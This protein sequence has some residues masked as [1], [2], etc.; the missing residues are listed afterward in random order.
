M[1]ELCARV[2]VSVSSYPGDENKGELDEPVGL[3]PDEIMRCTVALLGADDGVRP[4]EMYRPGGF[5]YVSAI[6]L[7]RRTTPCGTTIAGG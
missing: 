3:Y 2:D 7:S 4:C 6:F 1:M 5:L